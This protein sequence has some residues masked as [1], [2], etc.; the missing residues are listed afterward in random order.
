MHKHP[1]ITRGFSCLSEATAR[2]RPD[3]QTPFVIYSSFAFRPSI[4]F[5]PYLD[6]SGDFQ[7]PPHTHPVHVT[8]QKAI[9]SLQHCVHLVLWEYWLS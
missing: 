7:I 2:Q 8:G 5:N 6:Q 9:S 4:R 3:G 1:Y